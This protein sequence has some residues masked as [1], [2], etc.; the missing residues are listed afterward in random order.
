MKTVYFVRHGESVHNAAGR[1]NELDTPLSE[2]RTK[3]AE[4]IA[5]RASALP[6]ELIV[7]STLKRAQQ[8][9]T[10]VAERLGVKS[11]SSKFFVEGLQASRLLGKE[12][13][14]SEILEAIKDYHGNFTVAGYRFEDGENFDDLKTRALSALAYL[15]ERGEENIL[16]ITHGFFMWIIAAAA[17]FGNELTAEECQGV[18]RGLDLMENTGLTVLTHGA[19]SNKA[20]G[21]L[22]T[23]WQL[24]VWN[25]HAHLG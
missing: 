19:P 25:D 14:S 8:T 15:E 23:L 21:R 18:I 11:E 7:A 10:I 13:N 3:Q 9:A 2:R 16:V 22:P 4:E 1:F 24:K 20:V 6:I 5:E 12:V 17:V